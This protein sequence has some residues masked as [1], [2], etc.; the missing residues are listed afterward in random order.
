M[1]VDCVK[2]VFSASSV[3]RLCQVRFKCVKC[4]ECVKCV[5]SVSSGCLV[6]RGVARILKMGGQTREQCARGVPKFR[7]QKAQTH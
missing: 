3:C 6:G 2:C 4:V 7:D 1:C 5:S